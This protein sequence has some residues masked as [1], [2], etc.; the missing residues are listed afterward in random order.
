MSNTSAESLKTSTDKLSSPIGECG[1][2]SRYASSKR[3]RCLLTP[4]LVDQLPFHAPGLPGPVPKHMRS[5]LD[6]VPLTTEL[7]VSIL[8]NLIPFPRIHW[9][10]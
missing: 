7:C 9:G 8:S 10:W 3:P 1:H 5:I 6:T 4:R 2:L